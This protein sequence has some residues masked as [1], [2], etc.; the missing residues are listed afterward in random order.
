VGVAVGRCVGGSIIS[1]HNAENVISDGCSLLSPASAAKPR[2]M[3][4]SQTRCYNR[5]QNG[6][7]E[8]APQPNERLDP[9]PSQAPRCIQPIHARRSP[10]SCRAHTI[11]TT[12]FDDRS[13][14]PVL[15]H[16]HHPRLP[17]DTSSYSDMYSA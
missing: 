12:A 3:A 4:T 2:K 8:A 5:L 16:L 14:G 11:H 6:E 7:E 17:S 15:T 1:E 13:S 10:R 9:F